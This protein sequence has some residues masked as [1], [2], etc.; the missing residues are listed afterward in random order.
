MQSAHCLIGI[1]VGYVHRVVQASR[2]RALTQEGSCAKV[3]K[4]LLQ[5]CLLESG[6]APQLLRKV[7]IASEQLLWNQLVL[8]VVR[9]GETL[10]ICSSTAMPTVPQ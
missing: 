5:F 7:T 10:S 3:F 6:A 4:G 1:G 2:N 8:Q 9:V